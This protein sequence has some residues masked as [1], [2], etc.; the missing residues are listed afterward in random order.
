MSHDTTVTGN[1]LDG[2]DAGRIMLRRNASVTMNGTSAACGVT[3]EC[4]DLATERRPVVGSDAICG[5]SRD[6]A[7]GGS[8]GACLGD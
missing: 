7:D 6:T 2:V 1:G 3:E 5:T 8:W 4:D